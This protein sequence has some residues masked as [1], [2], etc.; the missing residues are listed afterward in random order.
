ML[1]RQPQPRNRAIQAAAGRGPLLLILVLA[2]TLLGAANA[3]AI[4]RDTV[5]ARAQTWV[6]NPVPYSQS[7][8]FGGYR[9]D[10][11]GYASMCWQ[12][13]TSWNTRTFYNVSRPISVDQLRPGDAMLKAGSHIRL[14]YGWVDA[15][16][17][18]YVTYEQTG[19]TT[20]SSIKSFL[21]DLGY[22]YIPTRYNGIADSPVSRNALLNGSFDVW[23]SGNPV[24]WQRGGSDHGTLV[25]HRQDVSKT[26][27]SS[28]ELINPAPAG[29]IAELSQT[30]SVT[31]GT[32]YTLSMWARTAGDPRALGLRL[33]YLGAS[34]AV[35]TD[36]RTTGDAW[37]LDSSAFKQM[38]LTAVAPPGAIAAVVTMRLA[39]GTSAGGVVG[40]AAVLDDVS[41]VAP[42]A[43]ITIR[44]STTATYVRATAVLSG[45]V[46]PTAA[47]GRVIIVYV[48]KPGNSRWSYSSNRGVYAQGAGAAWQYKYYFKPGMTKGVYNFR[49][50]VP[51][52]PGYSGSSSPTI[53][54]VRLK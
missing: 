50:E 18:Q 53:V 2:F 9:T 8:Y 28:L 34:D 27:R 31:A 36:V 45:S 17:T 33:T 30:A 35:L 54:S 1:V 42:Q 5:L 51:A 22:G 20:K 23:A 12:T 52:L 37:G 15:G 10:C 11:S 26:G 46:T 24:W 44:T 14:F 40:N 3:F 43:T 7:K 41:L 4:T 13:G 29:T 21:G 25:V 6:D 39:G 32:G 16:H 38:T 47:I 49:A 19:P 48:Q